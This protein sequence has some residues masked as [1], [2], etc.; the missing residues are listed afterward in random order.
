[1][2]F[3]CARVLVFMLSSSLSERNSLSLT[4]VPEFF[5]CPEY[6]GCPEF[7]VVVV[8]G[9][10]FVVVVVILGT[11]HPWQKCHKKVF[12]NRPFPTI[13]YEKKSLQTGWEGGGEN[14]GEG[15]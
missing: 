13:N 11:R 3:E 5:R 8:V 14:I 12:Q 15:H 2:N 7:V 10:G 6:F 9:G 1:M 4:N